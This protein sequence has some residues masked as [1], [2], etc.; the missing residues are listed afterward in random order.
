MHDHIVD[1]I[2]T[3]VQ[4]YISKNYPDNILFNALP[5]AENTYFFG[6]K[7][8]SKLSEETIE[9]IKVQAISLTKITPVEQNEM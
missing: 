9:T 1:N 4:V 8:N 2:C 6:C 7:Y 5:L 3:L